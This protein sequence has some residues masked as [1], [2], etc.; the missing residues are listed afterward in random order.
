MKYR[1]RKWRITVARGEP[2]VTT[3]GASSG[4]TMI[5]SENGENTMYSE[6]S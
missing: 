4:T 2:K 5:L 3:K 6:N 1:G